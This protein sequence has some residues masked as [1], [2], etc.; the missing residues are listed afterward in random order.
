MGI[1][2]TGEA[3]DPALRSLAQRA[4]T[5]DKRA[6]LDLGI[7]Y[8]EGRGVVPDI[9]KAERLYRLAASDSGGA[10][11]IY[12]PSVKNGQQGRVEKIS[13]SIR[14]SGLQEARARLEYLKASSRVV[15]SYKGKRDREWQLRK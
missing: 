4:A 1:P 14:Q 3:G 2:L 7:R 5:G 11:W 15:E 9:V 12:V 6:Q 13:D 10:L 8:E